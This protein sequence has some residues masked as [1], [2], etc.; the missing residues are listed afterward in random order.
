MLMNIY[1]L[2]KV[3]ALLLFLLG[4]WIAATAVEYGYMQGINPGSGFFPFWVGLLIAGLSLVN[5]VRNIVRSSGLT[6]EIDGCGALKSF[7]ISLLLLAFVL[8]SEAVGMLLG[9]FVLVLGVAWII[10]P[11]WGRRFAFKIVATAVLFPWLAYWVFS[12]YLKVP[13]P[14][15]TWFS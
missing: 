1:T 3:F 2:D 8:F 4:A 12:V 5:I 13:I 9:C 6:N 14:L 7:M 11:R 15:G 10:Q